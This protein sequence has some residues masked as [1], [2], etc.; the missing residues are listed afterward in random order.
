MNTAEQK[1]I[2]ATLPDETGEFVI[3]FFGIDR[4]GKI[5]SDYKLINVR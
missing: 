2:S 5:V 4:N 3:E 1:N